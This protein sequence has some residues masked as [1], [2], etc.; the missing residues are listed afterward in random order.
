[1]PTNAD[2]QQL[3]LDCRKRA[4]P[5]RPLAPG[6]HAPIRYRNLDDD[7]DTGTTV[8]PGG[9]EI[10]MKGNAQK[11]REEIALAKLFLDLAEHRPL[12]GLAHQRIHAARGA[13][14]LAMLDLSPDT[15]MLAD[16]AHPPHRD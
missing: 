11:A 9:L 14:D 16:L 1:M 7:K 2:E 4:G 8:F 3:G 13:L 10:Q 15:Q 5:R 6:G 12:P